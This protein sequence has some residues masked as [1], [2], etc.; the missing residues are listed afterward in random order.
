[1]PLTRAQC[2][3]LDP[4][5]LGDVRVVEIEFLEGDG[6]FDEWLAH[7]V[8]RQRQL[9]PSEFVKANGVVMYQRESGRPEVYHFEF[10]S[11]EEARGWFE[12]INALTSTGH[13]KGRRATAVQPRRT[14]REMQ[15]KDRQWKRS[16]PIERLGP[17]QS[18][19]EKLKLGRIVS[20]EEFYG[21]GYAKDLEENL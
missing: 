19:A 15:G 3:V 5:R 13:T 6:Q 18:Q 17:P 8:A 14:W 11:F 16:A 1:M 21:P 12:H 9:F 20:H 7:P 10:V 2:T 4:Q